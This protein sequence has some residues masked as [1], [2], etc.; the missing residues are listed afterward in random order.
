MG[1][2]VKYEGSWRSAPAMYVKKDS[3]WVRATSGWINNGSQWVRFF[4]SGIADTFNRADGSLGT[5]SDGSAAWSVTRGS[6]AINSNVA[7][8]STAAS[9]YPLAVVSLGS[10]TAVVQAD[11][12]VA[13][14]GIAFGVVDA[15]NWYGAFITRRTET[16]SCNPYS[17]N[18]FCCSTTFY[19]NDC[20][21]CGSTCV[22][23]PCANTN[24]TSDCT[25]CGST[26]LNYK[27]LENHNFLQYKCT[28]SGWVYDRSVNGE[29]CASC[30]CTNGTIAFVCNSSNIGSVTSIKNCTGTSGCAETVSCGC[31]N[32]SC[33]SCTVC[34]PQPCVNTCNSCSVCT[35]G[36]C[37]Q[38]CFSSCTGY[39]YGI[40]LVRCVNGTISELGTTEGSRDGSQPL[41]IRVSSTQTGITATAYSGSG[42]SGSL[43]SVTS[44]LVPT[45]ASHGI[46]I[47]PSSV[48]QGSTVDN[49]STEVQ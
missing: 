11:T 44:S 38:T 33:N 32:E 28:S 47:G 36:T 43:F 21:R 6:W 23:Q 13:G 4:A 3:A 25:K 5:T 35:G 41:S 46:L 18:P 20:V 37:Y 9:S 42:Q 45:G 8:S 12:P 15:N 34:E 40:R 31:I 14:S 27:K 49:F 26:C 10:S 2:Q 24:Y 29:Q 1:I 7:A 17:C 16:Y 30:T 19:S 22:S 48:S 39:Y